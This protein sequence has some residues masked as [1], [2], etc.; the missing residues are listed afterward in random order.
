MSG[1]K[2]AL[3]IRVLEDLRRG[4]L[5]ISQ[6]LTYSA[7]ARSKYRDDAAA[8]LVSIDALKAASK[9]SDAELMAA[10]FA[11][12]AEYDDPRF[13]PPPFVVCS[14]ESCGLH[15]PTESQGLRTAV[16]YLVE[17]RLTQHADEDPLAID[18]APS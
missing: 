9:P 16:E 18:P 3:A 17:H 6:A 1:S 2:H 15:A 7:G 12:R 13:G 14:T 8:L 11:I 4:H 5:A 10:L